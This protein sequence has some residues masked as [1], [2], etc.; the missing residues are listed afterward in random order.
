LPFTLQLDQNGSSV[1]GRIDL[2]KNTHSLNESGL[3]VG[4]V[5]GS[6]MFHLSAVTH[7]V[8][9]TEFSQS[10]ISNWLAREDEGGRM[11]GSFLMKQTFQNFWGMQTL[12][13]Q[14]ELMNVTRQL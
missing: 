2:Y 8:D 3:V 5:D 1:D 13:E 14:C 4:T 9:Q 6:G 10:E 7:S 11:T 12:S